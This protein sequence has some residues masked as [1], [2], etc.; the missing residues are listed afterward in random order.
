MT[1]AMTK[2]EPLADLEP[3]PTSFDPLKESALVLQWADQEDRWWKLKPP[4]GMDIH[5]LVNEPKLWGA[6][7]RK[8]KPVDRVMIDSPDG[9]VTDYV[10]VIDVD[11]IKL[12]IK[13]GTTLR[14]IMIP[15]RLPTWED[16]R[17]KVRYGAEA[18]GLAGFAA[19]SKHDGGRRTGFHKE[20]D[21]ARLEWETEGKRRVG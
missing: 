15:G 1:N 8:M 11:P 16:E 12:D 21:H 4:S 2:A 7:G 18:G 5:R 14:K 13:P 3:A 17:V 9:W 6:A 20:R 19:F 10:M